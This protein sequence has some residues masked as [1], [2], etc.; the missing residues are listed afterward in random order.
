MV[1]NF[2]TS[3]HLH[4]CVYGV[5]AASLQG[6][7]FSACVR[8]AASEAHFVPQFFKKFSSPHLPCM[9]FSKRT[10]LV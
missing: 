3:E 2:D 5:L 8:S 1:V 6:V 7:S 4:V 10:N 9:K